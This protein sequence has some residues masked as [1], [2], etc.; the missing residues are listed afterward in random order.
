MPPTGYNEI[1]LRDLQ[2]L[3]W[4]AIGEERNAV[5][6]RLNISRP[7]V[8]RHLTKIM[9][10]TATPS[11]TAAVAHV[12]ALGLLTPRD[13]TSLNSA[14]RYE[15]ARKLSPDAPVQAPDA[16][17]PLKRSAVLSEVAAYVRSQ[18]PR[19]PGSSTVDA[20]VADVMESLARELER[21]GGLPIPSPRRDPDAP[22]VPEQPKGAV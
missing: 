13:V 8:N 19:D 15:R 7:A 16:M 6:E 12:M 21:R 3:K 14:K 17:R 2:V 1:T 11:A 20:H 5:A 10:L 18:K 22:R 4:I 9:K